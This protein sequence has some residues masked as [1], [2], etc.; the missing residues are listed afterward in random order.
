MNQ[1]LQQVSYELA[2]AFLPDTAEKRQLNS[3][4]H[5]KTI[6][7]HEVPTYLHCFSKKRKEKSCWYLYCSC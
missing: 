7:L 3:N 1:L 4:F 6:A 5:C 2:I